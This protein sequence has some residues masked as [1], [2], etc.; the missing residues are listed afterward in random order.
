MP[1]IG[2]C[3]PHEQF[4]A[5]EL[6]ENAVKAVDAGFQALWTSDHFHPW[7]D[8]QGHA[9]HAWITMAAL[10][11]RTSGAPFGTA[12]TCPGYRYRPA[13]VAQAF[14]SLGVLYPGRVY[15]GVGTGEA[16]NEVPAGGGWG[17]WRE[18]ADRMV[19]SIQ[20]IRRLWQGDWVTHA[21][22]Y[23]QIEN[24]KLYDVPA[25][26]VPIY[27]AAGGPKA[28]RIAGE[29]GDGLIVGASE[30]G[31]PTLR[32]AFEE[33]AIAAGKDPTTLPTLVE[34]FVIV[35]GKAEAEAGARLWRFGPSAWKLLDEP[36]P[37]VIE[38]MAAAES[39]LED[40]YSRWVVSEEPE[41]HIAGVQ[42]LLDKGATHI[43]V[44]ATQPDQERVIDFY[45]RHVL[46]RFR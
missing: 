41:A 29:H 43:F 46:P 15:L 26:P 10:G 42:T 8:N 38:R 19:E 36:D 3:L 30:L 31:E 4:P 12:V 5:P 13:E 27:I 32:G 14:A 24:A 37:R 23:Y 28:M 39:S 2:F 33:G 22:R 17:P 20:L 1:T 44:H 9:G 11:Q 16:L 35:G 7:Q 40:V 34:H 6:V 45:S 21:G 25:Q 18:R